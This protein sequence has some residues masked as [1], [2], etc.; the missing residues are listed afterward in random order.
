M[1]LLNKVK[2]RFIRGTES[3]VKKSNSNNTKSTGLKFFGG[4]LVFNL[5]CIA[6]VK[7]FDFIKAQKDKK[8]NSERSVKEYHSYL[9][10]KSV[11]LNEE[12]AGV[13]LRSILSNVAIDLSDCD[14]VEDSFISVSGLLSNISLI[15]PEEVNVRFDSLTRV[16]SLCNLT[17][18]YDEES[19]Y[20]TLYIAVNATAC[21]ID[22]LS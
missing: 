20:P 4:F 12:L 2:K 8:L 1:I 14:F 3:T 17:D 21:K 6:A 19:E 18:D 10:N 16:S 11:C 9:G 15:V 22:I 13:S 5:I 7:I